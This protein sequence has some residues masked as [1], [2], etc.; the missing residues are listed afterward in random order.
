MNLDRYS[1][2]AMCWGVHPEDSSYSIEV[3]PM[4][5]DE[6]EWVRYEDARGEIE[7]L[8]EALLKCRDM[9]GHPDNI[10]I[11]D[12]ALAVPDQEPRS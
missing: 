2:S 9:V 5:H 7:R 6:G 4:A 12:A 1:M 10:A 8:R 3:E 11:I